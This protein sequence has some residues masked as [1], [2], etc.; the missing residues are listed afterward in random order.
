VSHLLF[1]RGALRISLLGTNG[2]V[3]AGPFEACNNVDSHSQGPWPDGTFPY[4]GYNAHPALSDPN[5]EYG[6]YGILIFDVPDHIGMGVHSGR[7]DIPDGLGRT[8][9][10]HCTLG[11]VRTTDQAMA[12]FLRVI[13]ADSLL[14]ISVARAPR[15]VYVTK[16]RGLDEVRSR[17]L[18]G[19]TPRA[20]PPGKMTKKARLRTKT[21]M[22][23]HAR[24]VPGKK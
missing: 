1:D 19:L 18:K 24:G 5:S 21:K 20:G 17:E 13:S 2:T 22:L 11:C 8:G 4:I 16:G 9:P 23:S 6:A 10:Q 12:S 3:L 15:K 7:R 14:G